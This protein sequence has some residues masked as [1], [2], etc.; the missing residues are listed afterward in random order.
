MRRF[1]AARRLRGRTV[2]VQARGVAYRGKY[3]RRDVDG[4]VLVDAQ[5]LDEDSRQPEWQ[6]M[7][8]EVLVAAGEVR[9]VQVP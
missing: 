6:S 2:V 1:L 8:G 9:H 7:D 4:V 3:V 5:V